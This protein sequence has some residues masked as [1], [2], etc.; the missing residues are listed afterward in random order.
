MKRCLMQRIIMLLRSSLLTLLLITNTETIYAKPQHLTPHECPICLAQVIR[1]K[2]H[3]AIVHS[4]RRP[5]TCKQCRKSFKSKDN[6]DEHARLIHEK[7][8]DYSCSCGANYKR[9]SE[10]IACRQS[11][12]TRTRITRSIKHRK[13]RDKASTEQVPNKPASPEGDVTEFG[14]TME[15]FLNTIDQ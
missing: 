9:A 10:A 4:N 3:L 8:Y 11:K 6:R 1:I 7:R 13:S 12:H 15:E 2:R 14:M 5:F